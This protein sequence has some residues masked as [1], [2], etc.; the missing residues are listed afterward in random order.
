MILGRQGGGGGGPEGMSQSTNT[1]L[2]KI[3]IKY[4]KENREKHAYP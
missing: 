3:N 2:L 1:S 4:N